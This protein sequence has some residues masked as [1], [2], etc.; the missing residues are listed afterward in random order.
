MRGLQNREQGISIYLRCF[1]KGWTQISW[2]L[3]LN[4][5]SSEF[6][7]CFSTTTRI[8]FNE[9][10]TVCWIYKGYLVCLK[11]FCETTGCQFAMF[12]YQIVDDTISKRLLNFSI[13]ITPILTFLKR[14]KN[15]NI[16]KM[17][18]SIA[19]PWTQLFVTVEAYNDTIPS[20]LWLWKY[21]VTR[22]KL[23]KRHLNLISGV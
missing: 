5:C 3:W 15:T 4:S 12:K 1:V 14:K 17:K 11:G 18:Y 19:L 13:S 21:Q 7:W 23:P 10:F 20:Q 9:S 8:A 2:S 22:M 16:D 6:Y